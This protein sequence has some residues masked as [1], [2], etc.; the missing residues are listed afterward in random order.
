MT[1]NSVVKIVKLPI[2]YEEAVRDLI[3]CQSLDEAKY[4]ADKA[5]ALSAYSKIYR[6]NAA[7]IEARKLRLHSYRRM[8]E[9]AAEIRPNS[10]IPGKRPGSRAGSAPGPSSLLMESGLSRTAASEARYLAK[11][12]AEK[13]QKLIDLPRPPS[14]H[15]VMITRTKSSAAWSDFR[16]QGVGSI[17]Y[18]IKNKSAK[19][20]ALQFSYDEGIRAKIIINDLLEWLDEFER[21]LPK[22]DT[23]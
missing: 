16:A 19:D 14:P 21:F 4:F 2:V 5:E 13:F 11:M 8:G 22:K 9:L 12:S 6:D 10:F 7:G 20:M 18:W 1:N 3:A 17:H 23:Q 15:T